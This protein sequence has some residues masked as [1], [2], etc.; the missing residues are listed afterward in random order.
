MSLA[1]DTDF[2]RS[3]HPLPVRDRRLLLRELG[4]DGIDHRDDGSFYAWLGERYRAGEIALVDQALARCSAKSDERD[5]TARLKAWLRA[6]TGRR[7]LVHLGQDIALS[8][9]LREAR[10]L[11]DDTPAIL[12]ALAPSFPHLLEQDSGVDEPRAA[13]EGQAELPFS[14]ESDVVFARLRSALDALAADPHPELV[15]R[16]EQLAVAIERHVALA[17][18]RSAALAER[19]TVLSAKIDA[20]GEELSERLPA[21]AD[22]LDEADLDAIDQA[23]VVLD[24]A[25]ATLTDAQTDWR[26]AAGLR[27]ALRDAASARMNDA[28]EAVDAAVTVLADRIGGGAPIV[29]EDDSPTAKP[30]IETAPPAAPEVLTDPTPE[31]ELTAAEPAFPEQVVEPA[32]VASSP[33]PSELI[34][35]VIPAAP[36]AIEPELPP[37][38]DEPQDQLAAATPTSP[39]SVAGVW[40]EWLRTA[41]LA[42]RLGLAVHIADARR[43]AGMDGQAAI[44]GAAIEGLLRGRRVEAA[45]DRAWE[46][47]ESLQAS[48]LAAKTT[49]EDGAEAT[50]LGLI[51]Y[52]GAIRPALL[53][54]GAG[55][56]VLEAL[57]GGTAA[58]LNPLTVALRN[59]RALRIGSLGELAAPVEAEGRRRRQAAIRRELEQWLEQARK[60]NTSFHRATLVW[61]ALVA[62]DGTIGRACT[63]AL[64]GS[65]GASKRIEAVLEPVRA[66]VEAVIAA[67]QTAIAPRTR[68]D[69][70]EGNALKQLKSFVGGA[71]EL[72]ERWQRAHAAAAGEDRYRPERNE[73][74]RAL[75]STAGE[76]TRLASGGAD[77]VLA[78]DLFTATA[79]ALKDQ[80]SGRA[81]PPASLSEELDWEIALLPGFPLNARSALRLGADDVEDLAEAAAG[82][83]AGV[84]A[85]AEAFRSALAIGAASS[86]ARLIPHLPT[87]DQPAAEDALAELR[88]SE[89]L[90]LVNRGRALRSHLDDLQIA[91]TENRP[92]VDELE[93][94]M[95]AFEQV[96]LSELPR[97]V[98]EV[99]DLADFPAVSRELDRIER[100]LNAA[101]RSAGERLEAR[102]VELEAK[103]GQT[104]AEC[105][106]Q[107]AEGDLG[108]LA[109][110]LDQIG[111]YGLARSVEETSLTLLRDHVALIEALGDQPSLPFGNLPKAARQGQLEG[112][113]D[114]TVL[115]VDDRQRADRLLTAWNALRRAAGPQ[116]RSGDAAANLRK[117]VADVLTALQFTGVRVDKCAREKAWFQ[118]VAAVDPLRS[119]D[120]CL[121][122]AFG[123]ERA[124]AHE[125]TAT[126]AV[127]VVGAADVASALTLFDSLP[128]QVLLLFTEVL[129]PRQRRDFQRKA[130][131]GTRAVALVDAVAITTLARTPLAGTRQFFDLAI[132]FGA[133]QPYADKGSETS[134]EM[135]FGREDE[136]RRLVDPNGACFVYGGRQLGKTA[137]L[138]QIEM[139]ENA[140]ADRV[141]IYCD[142]KPIGE[143][144]PTER[145]WREIADKLRERK[146]VLPDGA[147]MVERLRAWIAAR[148]GRYLLILLDEADAFLEQEMLDNFP[149]VGAMKELMAETRRGVKLV[150][151]G[152]HNVQRFYH[153]PNSPLLH[154]G[155]PINVGPLLGNDRDAARQMAFE[156]MASLGLGFE[157]RTD[158]Y[159]MLSLVGFY[160]SLM[161]SFGKAV[162]EAA[163]DQLKRPGDMRT[164]PTAITRAV[165]D[166]CFKR[167]TFRTGVVERFRQTLKLDERYELVTYAVWQRTQED[168]LAGRLAGRGYPASEIFRLAMDWWPAGFRDT[169]SLDSFTAILDEMFEMGVLARDGERYALRSQRIAA[170]LGGKAEIDDQLLGFSDR[171]PRRRPD[172]L[173]SHRQIGKAWSPFS[174]RQE[175]NLRTRWAAPDGH[176]VTLVTV[177][178]ATGRARV[179]E[180]VTA[181]AREQGWPEPRPI[182]SEADAAKIIAT[183]ASVDVRRAAAPGRPVLLLQEGPWPAPAALGEL[184]RHRAFR[185][186]EHPMHLVCYG[187][188][189]ATGLDTDDPELLRVILGPLPL[190]AMFHWMNRWHVPFAADEI[191][192][193]KLRNASGGFLAVLDRIAPGGGE[194]DDQAHL[195]Q[196]AE[197]TAATLTAAD[198]GMEAP[199]EDFARKL[200]GVIGSEQVEQLESWA[201]DVDP[202]AGPG[203][204]RLLETLGVLERSAGGANRMLVGFNPVAAR[205]LS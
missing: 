164:M 191:A 10:A 140:S 158:A 40:G 87:A 125:S 23:L 118:L 61:H 103:H 47:Y 48:L 156:P 39:S 178:P 52:A 85:P 122:P 69:P 22:R 115:P 80:L 204:A 105:R 100:K 157:R 4:M 54:S 123:S 131:A 133:A 60:R 13:G 17:S 12:R 110:E 180:A 37:E 132:P 68:P 179:A 192:Q 198:L 57:G 189:H 99:G 98:A 129:T 46:D 44:P 81:E 6:R 9:L 166:G 202:G 167:Q 141:A 31:P 14:T 199:A 35:A 11:L 41:L 113:L 143:S 154:L 108:T 55:W 58:A 30:D 93:R 94:E 49:Q 205:I 128:N 96:E 144:V 34:N 176:R 38:I 121:V 155:A 149:I 32:T 65:A 24:A 163:N 59:L 162:V 19:R 170:M 194:Q 190:D 147:T 88:R 109:E 139:R 79:R 203:L 83:E 33:D 134:I 127:A 5:S 126:Y 153:A 84:P 62:P 21:L 175:A 25:R 120:H 95:S 151:A 138:K 16:A 124:A 142:I 28:E 50:A 148:P 174:L 20:L 172:P 104:L 165:I 77:L 112:A 97:E 7:E 36:A 51:L 92:E 26:D 197:A 72:L 185:D 183:A 111:R 63:A 177:S 101:R 8:V 171:A 117:A 181:L 161:Q 27:R 70:I 42:D 90:R 15:D 116:A 86:A 145:V 193:V 78:A 135:F 114:F 188:P 136:M 137:L 196:R 76:V 29:S 184:R 73:L 56:S 2:F 106:T 53:Q 66:D 160:P 201:S 64:D 187:E 186:A 200:L 74:L 182:T 43:L 195:I 146:V 45:Y 71:L 173:T 130:R 107:L 159:H 75:D 82:L 3:F 150:F 119:R 102:I 89:E 168:N 67:V 1:L 152:L 91:L 169:D 18:Q